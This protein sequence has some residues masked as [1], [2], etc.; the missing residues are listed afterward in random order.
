MQ[1][2]HGLAMGANFGVAV[3]K[4]ASTLSLE[5]LAGGA[6][7]ADFVADMM[8]TAGG[9][10]FEEIGNRR[11]R[12]QGFEELDLGV[13]KVDEHHRHAVLGLRPGCRYACSQRLAIDA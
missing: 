5:A 12:A 8:D 1:K 11:A 13:G 3:A 2:Q 6:K 7:V 4:H 10:L 9:I